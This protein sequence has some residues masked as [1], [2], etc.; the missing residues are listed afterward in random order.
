MIDFI[1][2]KLKNPV[3]IASGIAGFGEE[4]SQLIDLN[5]CAGFITKTITVKPK[6]GNK[7][8]RIIETPA[9]MINRIGLENPGLDKFIKEKLPVMTR[10]LRIPVIVSIAGD[11]VEE[12]V[13]ITEKLNK[14]TKI[15][16]AIELN[17]SCPNVKYKVKCYAQSTELTYEIVNKVKQVSKLPV[18]AKLTPNVTDIAEI[19]LS[20]EKAGADAV[21]LINT[22]TGL[23]ILNTGEFVIGG[24]SGP[25]IKP[26]ALRCIYEV[27]R[28]TE[29]P[30]MGVGGITCAEDVREFLNAGADTVAVG[31]ALF[32]N[33]SLIKEIIKNKS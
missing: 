17:L 27:R 25:C 13:Q 32:N 16:S 8:P 15:I 20:T 11:T 3:F 33:P 18:I 28:K 5:I 4:Y 31:S 9:G 22:V 21:S 23:G 2:L 12:Y 29:I 30:I 6:Q 1:G 26:V 14:Y 10:I 24:L 19:A 7:P